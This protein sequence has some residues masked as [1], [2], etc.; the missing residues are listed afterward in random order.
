MDASEITGYDIIASILVTSKAFKN[1]KLSVNL[2]HQMILANITYR[3][4]GIYKLLKYRKK[5]LL[6]QAERAAKPYLPEG[7]EI[8]VFYDEN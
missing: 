4:A 8:K 1:V 5:Y 2:K 6:V 7:F 3:D